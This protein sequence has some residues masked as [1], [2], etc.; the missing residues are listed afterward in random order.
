M[1]SSGY[2]W[3]PVAYPNHI[4]L[5]EAL[6]GYGLYIGFNLHDQEG[7]Q[8]FELR[9]P[10]MARAMGVDPA[11]QQSIAFHISNKTYAD[12]LAITVVQPL[13]DEGVVSLI[14]YERW[15]RTAIKPHGT[16]PFHSTSMETLSHPLLYTLP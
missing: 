16:N 8:P 9:Y 14:R 3:D 13:L 6:H 7:V 2:T 12:A 4:E 15:R 1:L 11:T 10:Q 5:L